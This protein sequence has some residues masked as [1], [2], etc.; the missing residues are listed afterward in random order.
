MH[1]SSPR[2]AAALAVAAA[3]LLAPTA[4]AATTRAKA[5]RVL[6]GDSVRVAVAGTARTVDLLGVDSP[7][8][9]DCFAAEATTAL[10]RMLPRGATVRLT[11][12][13][14]RR[15]VYVQRGGRLVNASM[16]AGGFA[17]ADRT[18]RLRNGNRLNAAQTRAKAAGRGLWGA[19]AKPPAPVTSPPAAPV[20]PAGPDAAARDALTQALA[21]R[22]LRHFESSTGGCSA[23]CFQ[24]EEALEFC[25]DGT[26][27]HDFKSVVSVVLAD[28]ID[29]VTRRD[30]GTWRV[31]DATIEPEGTLSGTI[32]A[33]LQRGSAIASGNATPGAI[34]LRTAR[35]STDGITAINGAQWFPQASPHCA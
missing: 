12:D 23:A 35:I 15:G 17:T 27:S 6:D 4:D 3:A 21:G 28:P 31:R 10:R 18:A 1:P 19:C 30:E 8:G 5:V 32:E 22:V 26:F 20:A 2:T 25:S 14:R 16:L 33:T 7:V 29:P 13:G 24:T 34:Q 9:R 11:T